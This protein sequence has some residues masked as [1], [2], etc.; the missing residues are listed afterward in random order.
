MKKKT[1]WIS[2]LLV[3]AIICGMLS[4]CTP[5]SKNMKFESEAAMKKYMKGTFE[6][7]SMICMIDGNT[8]QI[9]R[10]DE[11]F[12]EG[13]DMDKLIKDTLKLY[14]VE[15]LD[16]PGY[17]NKLGFEPE[18]KKVKY[19][20][21]KG[22]VSFDGDDYDINEEGS[23]VIGDDVLVWRYEELTYST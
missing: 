4:G 2:V 1:A 20:Y 17:I 6:G 10:F 11:L 19:D 15:F 23:L 21:E 18:E 13:E 3:T 12:P 5:A 16:L 7:E 8:V 22:I 9:V 14:S